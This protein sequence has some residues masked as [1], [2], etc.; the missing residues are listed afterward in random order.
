MPF[1]QTGP[2]RRRIAVIG[3]GIT[4]MGAALRLAEHHDVTLIEAEG[5]LGGHARTREVGGVPV[6]TGFIVF[7]HATY[8]R[9]TR[10]F[11]ELD[12]PTA[13]SSMSFG[14]SARGGA[15][16]YAVLDAR[17]Y[18][19]QARN[20]VSPGHW[21]MLRDIF[22]FNG[23][24]EAA[25]AEDP[26]MT[27]R[28]LLARMGLGRRFADLYLAPFTGAIWST[29]LSGVMDFQAAALLR[30]FRNHGL[31][32]MTGQHQWYTVRGGSREYVTR[33]GAALARAGVERRLGAPVRSVRRIPLG[34]RVDGEAFDEVVLALHSDDALA[35]LEDADVAERDVLGAIRYQPN[36]MIL[37]TD[38]SVM[39]KR[40]R[41]WSAWNYA[42]PKEGPGDR[43]A[44]TYWMNALQPLPEGRDVFV[45]LNDGGRIDPATVHDRATFR[46]PVLD[47]AATEA[48]GRLPDI[49]GRRATW[50]CGAWARNGFHEDGLATA[51]EV[52]EAILARPEAAIAAE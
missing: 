23:G 12:V 8:P 43:I 25:V 1:D 39:P 3:G 40:R 24:A 21:R 7:N 32:D 34:A 11:A 42:E 35:V 36:E 20:I 26:D 48:Q 41:V 14:V 10:L 29:P 15:L 9:L 49:Q 22:R 5:R 50:F 30:F 47:A 17:A 27:V 6:D 31:M 51:E 13:P 18:F 37:H 16:E 19:A 45:T 33:L 4:G 44:L 28:D 46:H 2:V 38:P 52:A